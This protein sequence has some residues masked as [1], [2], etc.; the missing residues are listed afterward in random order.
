MGGGSL[1]AVRVE[2][3]PTVVHKYGIGLEDVRS[4]LAST[5]TNRPKGQLADGTTSR[6]IRTNDQLFK[7][8]AYRDLIVAFRNGAPMQLKDLGDVV[9]SVE[10]VRTEGLVNGKTAVMVVIFRSPGANIIETVDRIRGL[11]PQLS[12]AIPQDINL[13]VT[14]DRSPPIR[15]SL[16][17][18]ERTLVISGT[19]VILVVFAFLRSFRATLIPAV[20]VPVSLIGTFA[21]MYLF[22]YSLDNLSL[23]ALTIATGFV[24]DDAIVVLENITRYIEKGE[25]PFRAALLG[26]KEI[27]FT[28]ISMSTS[29]VAVF[30]PLLL[31]GG[32]VGRLFREFSVTLSCAIL[33]SL[34]ISLTTTPM[35]CAI[36]LRSEKGLVHGRL[37]RA[38]EG[39][40]EFLRHTYERTLRWALRHSR[41]DA[42]PDLAHLGDQYPLVYLHSQGL[43]PRTGHRPPHRHDPGGPGHLLSGHAQEAEGSGGRHQD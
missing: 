36:F 30:I 6:E 5:N 2:L 7:A 42:L 17:D 22:G 26:A 24:V 3:N 16:K 19:L 12:A 21:L 39:V 4:T 37:Y 27:A 25:K 28:V 31:M 33:I 18:V 43:F 38:S 23:M 35:M 29:L 40:F 1:P 34:V 32:M 13:S 15:A 10:D 41:T 14:V 9:D 8:A 20:A 11:L